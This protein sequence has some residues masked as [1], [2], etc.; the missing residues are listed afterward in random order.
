RLRPRILR[1]GAPAG[2][3]M[4]GPARWQPEALNDHGDDLA[5]WRAFRRERVAGPG[6]WLAVVGLWWLPDGDGTNTTTISIGSGS[7]ND[8]VLP[9][10]PERLGTLRIGGGAVLFESRGAAAARGPAQL[11]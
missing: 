11:A 5:R 8:I 1:A 9:S 10:G 4:Q 6:G 3:E 7:A 2:T